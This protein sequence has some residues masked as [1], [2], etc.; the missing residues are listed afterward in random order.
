MHTHGQRLGAGSEH[1]RNHGVAGAKRFAV[2]TGCSCE[3]RAIIKAE[4]RSSSARRKMTIYFVDV[5]CSLYSVEVINSQS[6]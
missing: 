1:A 4:M 2:Y 5:L 3:A 6:R